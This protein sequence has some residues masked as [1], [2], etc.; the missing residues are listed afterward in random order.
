MWNTGRNTSV[1]VSD[2]AILLHAHTSCSVGFN[3]QQKLKNERKHVKTSDIFLKQ[4]KNK[5][6]KRK[7]FKKVKKGGKSENKI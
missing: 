4:M 3:A 5:N 7:K 6:E 2:I 1:V